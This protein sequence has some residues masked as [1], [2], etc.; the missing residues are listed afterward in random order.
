MILQNA[1][2]LQPSHTLAEQRTRLICGWYHTVARIRLGVIDAAAPVLLA[3]HEDRVTGIPRQRQDTAHLQPRSLRDAQAA[4][5]GH[6]T[7][8]G[9]SNACVVKPVQDM[10]CL[11]ADF[12]RD[13]LDL[14]L[15]RNLLGRKIRELHIRQAG[16]G[17]G[18]PG[19]VIDDPAPADPAPHSLDDLCPLFR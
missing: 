1:A 19:L 2:Q 7:G 6:D 8:P 10:V 15:L 12:R 11:H 18:F 16:L 17:V 4:G 13:F 3:V 14:F 9:Q 5:L